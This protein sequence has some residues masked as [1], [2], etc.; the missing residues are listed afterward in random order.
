VAVHAFPHPTPLS[1]LQNPYPN[2]L[3]TG[4]GSASF[5]NTY[6]AVATEEGTLYFACQI[7]GH[8]LAG[9]KITVTATIPNPASPPGSPPPL[10]P[11]SL[12]PPPPPPSF[13]WVQLV[14]T[15]SPEDYDEAKQASLRQII[16]SVSGVELD[17]VALSVTPGSVHLEFKV[18]TDR[19]GSVKAD[20]EAV[21]PDAASASTLLGIDVEEVV[22]ISSTDTQIYEDF[23]GDF[24]NSLAIAMG[25][26]IA[27]V[28]VSTIAVIAGIVLCVFC[29]CRAQQKTKA[30]ASV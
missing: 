24:E 30:V 13:A 10:S 27:I 4:A 16:A 20:L 11:P 14:A 12:P 23:W 8:C 1:P 15:G 17:S 5:P 22:L 18:Y 7:S 19:S 25:V 28:V 29:C 3:C 6:E 21:M 26:I 9:Q 2:L